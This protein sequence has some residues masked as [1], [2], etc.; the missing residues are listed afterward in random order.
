MLTFIGVVELYQTLLQGE[1]APFKLGF[2]P[3][4]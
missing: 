3:I 2:A 4:A 1:F